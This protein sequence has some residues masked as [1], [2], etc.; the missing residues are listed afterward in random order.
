MILTESFLYNRNSTIF[1][2]TF[3]C[4]LRLR[5]IGTLMNSAQIF[6]DLHRWLIY[7]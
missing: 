5:N 7:T 4:L 3:L 2:G 1:P 6:Y